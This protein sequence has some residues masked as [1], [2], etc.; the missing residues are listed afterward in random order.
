[1]TTYLHPNVRYFHEVLLTR[2]RDKPLEAGF[3]AELKAS[4]YAD[5]DAYAAIFEKTNG[6]PM[7]I[8]FRHVDD[9]KWFVIL[10]EMSEHDKVEYPYRVQLFSVHG[11]TSHEPVRSLDDAVAFMLRMDATPETDTGILA[12]LQDTR[13]FRLGCHYAGL[14][15]L[16]SQQK[17]SFEALNADYARFKAQLEADNV[18]VFDVALWR[19]G[20]ITA[21][22][23]I[24]AL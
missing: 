11:F 4:H 13:D 15:T 10:P 17:C 22:N 18:P 14:L 2:A 12:D 1:M 16:L 23:S 7:G 3:L 20:G 8:E 5:Q 24:P 6:N 9:G 21:S 19:S